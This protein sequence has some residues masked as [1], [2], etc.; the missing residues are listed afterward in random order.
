MKFSELA[1]YLEK[2]EENSSRIEITKI[3]SSMFNK[4]G[5]EEIDKMTYLV[6]GKLAPN[7][8]NIVF[9]IADRM[10]LRA[11]AEA[12]GKEIGEVKVLYK[13]KGDVGDVVTEFAGGRGRS[14]SVI[15]VYERMLTIAQDEGEGSQER[16]INEIAKLLKDLDSYWQASTWIFRQNNIRRIILDE[17]WR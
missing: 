12:Y 2:L 15:Q 8:K 13:Q 16:K 7:Y 14:L 9:N 5:V 17:K 4:A 1:K 11:V 3:L 6:L 10:M